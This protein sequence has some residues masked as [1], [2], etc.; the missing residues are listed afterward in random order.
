M[1]IVFSFIRFDDPSLPIIQIMNS[2][3]SPFDFLQ[4][5][6]LE[7]W[8]NMIRLCVNYRLDLSQM[9]RNVLQSLPIDLAF[10]ESI[11]EMTTLI[12]RIYC[13][14]SS[15][16]YKIDQFLLRFPISVLSRFMTELSG[17]MNYIYLLQSSISYFAHNNP[18][19]ENQIV[20]RGFSVKGPQL[21][22]LYESMIG[23]IIVWPEFARTSLNLALV[24]EENV[25]QKEGILFEIGLHSG[26]EVVDI[27]QFSEFPTNSDEIVIAASSGF[28]V[29]A[30]D[31]M[32]IQ[33]TDGHQFIIPKVRLS[34]SF[35]WFDVEIERVPK[36]LV[37]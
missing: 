30:V 20:Y 32:D 2:H 17:I 21:R 4:S 9:E 13:I 29:I 1:G 37:L 24:I 33:I 18:L 23:E 34:Y 26:D 25:K 7:I 35:S 3:L 28:T 5:R 6:C 31:S 14:E 8:K 16:R 10:C 15:L 12:F 27:S 22:P 11:S 36:P 19:M